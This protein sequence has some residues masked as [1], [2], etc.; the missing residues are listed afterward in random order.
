MAHVRQ[1]PR[2]DLV[3]APQMIGFLIQL[4]VERYH[5]AVGIFQFAIENPQLFLPLAQFFQNLQ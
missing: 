4:G 5:A 1:K 2:L 3:R